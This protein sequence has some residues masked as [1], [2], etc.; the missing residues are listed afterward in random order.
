MGDFSQN[1]RSYSLESLETLLYN[2]VKAHY[3][4]SGKEKVKI[5]LRLKHLKE[6]MAISLE[7]LE[8]LNCKDERNQKILIGAS[9]LHDIEKFKD[10]EK[11]ALL[12]SI[13]VKAYEAEILRMGFEKDEVALI[14]ELILYHN[15]GF[16]KLSVKGSLIENEENKQRSILIHILQDADEISKI[17]KGKGDPYSVLWHQ[18]KGMDKQTKQKEIICYI[19]KKGLNTPEAYKIFEERFEQ[20]IKDL[21]NKQE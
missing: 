11:H 18:L 17:Y 19:T 20:Y 16:Y 14:S 3:E 6:V 13:F 7:L 15:Q 2:F 4:A 12:G 8:K 21:I 9:Y 1:Q 5:I 10:G